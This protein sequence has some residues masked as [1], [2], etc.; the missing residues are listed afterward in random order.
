MKKLS[1]IVSIVFL[2][3]SSG[4]ASEKINLDITFAILSCSDGAL[5]YTCQAQEASLFKQEVTFVLIKRVTNDDFD[6]YGSTL[7]KTLV[8][9]ETTF[10]F[11][12][13]IEKIVI[14]ADKTYSYGIR[15]FIR[16]VATNQLTRFSNNLE[17][18][19]PVSSIYD[20]TFSGPEYS[21]QG[22]SLHPQITMRPPSE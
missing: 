22:N 16:N 2:Y 1:L 6:S 20:L 7:S 11:S 4:F 18:N 10:E 14:V 9:G 13:D 3:G 12:M 5:G 21:F 8:A 15:G 19:K 17:I